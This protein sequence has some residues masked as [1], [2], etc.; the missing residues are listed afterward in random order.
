MRFLES[1][2]VGLESYYEEG[3]TDFEITKKLNTDLSDFK[4]W[5]DFTLLGGVIGQMY[6]QIE[7]DSF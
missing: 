2:Y 5:Y 6:L 3:L 1:L 7:N 4:Q